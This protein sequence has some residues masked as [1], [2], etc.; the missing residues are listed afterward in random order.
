MV[1]CDNCNSDVR[2]VWRHRA[3]SESMTHRR[4]E[5]VC[6]DCHPELPV[7]ADTPSRTGTAMADGGHAANAC[8]VC[9][10]PTVTGEDVCRCAECGWSRTL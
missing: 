2:E 8:P 7:P 6:A 5:W 3:H 10:A 1:T 9:S 4:I